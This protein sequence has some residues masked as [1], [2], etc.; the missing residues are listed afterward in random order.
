MTGSSPAALE[1][2]RALSREA[3]RRRTGICE[4]CGDE[5]R[6][7]G[8]TTNG[9]SRLCS[10]CGKKAAGE[11][12][13]GGGPMQRRLYALVGQNSEMRY[14]EICAALQISK[15]YA[16]VMLNYEL[17]NDRIRRVRRGVYTLP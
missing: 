11:T 4:E 13:R 7:N 1:R 16:G 9:T 10:R 17:R 2:S 3:K 5:T 15:D 12:K 8:H 6:Y 14:S